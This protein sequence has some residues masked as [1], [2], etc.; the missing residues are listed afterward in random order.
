MCVCVI[1]LSGMVTSMD[2]AVGAIMKTLIKRRMF[3]NTLI[4]FLS[5]VSIPSFRNVDTVRSY[6]IRTRFV[7]PF[8]LLFGFGKNNP[9]TCSNYPSLTV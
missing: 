7:R 6:V 2:D 8:L 1:S 5:D 3:D 4:V 9:E